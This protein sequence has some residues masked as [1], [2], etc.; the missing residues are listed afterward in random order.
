VLAVLYAH[1]NTQN[2]GLRGELLKTQ[3]ATQTLP[4]PAKPVLSPSPATGHSVPVSSAAPDSGAGVLPAGKATPIP[5]LSIAEPGAS[6]VTPPKP[7]LKR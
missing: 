1:R 3:G 2:S 7:K 5:S 4:S 6:P